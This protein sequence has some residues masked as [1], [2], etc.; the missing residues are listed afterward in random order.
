[1]EK[2]IVTKDLMKS[3]GKLVAK[4]HVSIGEGEDIQGAVSKVDDNY[5]MKAKHEILNSSANRI[6]VMGEYQV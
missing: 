2:A 6:T 5:K 1:M 3:H 4:D